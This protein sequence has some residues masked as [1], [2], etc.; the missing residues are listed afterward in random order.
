MKSERNTERS[1]RAW[2]SAHNIIIRKENYNEKEEGA[3]NVER[4]EAKKRQKE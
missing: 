2:T 1:K 3:V 4:I